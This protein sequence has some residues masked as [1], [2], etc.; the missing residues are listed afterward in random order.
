MTGRP[1]KIAANTMDMI[2]CVS[3]SSIMGEM[4]KNL[5]RKKKMF[6]NIIYKVIIFFFNYN[7]NFKKRL[8]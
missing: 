5:K 6:D 8:I 1:A 4:G 7:I 2:C 3:M